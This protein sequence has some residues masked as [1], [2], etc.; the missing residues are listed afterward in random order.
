MQYTYEIVFDD[1]GI[2]VSEAQI[3]EWE[4]ETQEGSEITD[5]N[6]KN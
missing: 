6:I 1:N 4:V 2:K 3:T 5:E